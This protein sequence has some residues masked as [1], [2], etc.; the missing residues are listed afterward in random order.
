MKASDNNKRPRYIPP[1]RIRKYFCR[2]IK[3]AEKQIDQ[4]KSNNQWTEANRLGYIL[5]NSWWGYKRYY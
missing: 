1:Y 4:L 2:K 5:R 3:E